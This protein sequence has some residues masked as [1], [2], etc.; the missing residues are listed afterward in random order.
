MKNLLDDFVQRRSLAPSTTAKQLVDGSDYESDSDDD[1]EYDDEDGLRK[2]GKRK[3]IEKP[4]KVNESS[5]ATFVQ[6]SSCQMQVYANAK[7]S[8]KGYDT[9]QFVSSFRKALVPIGNHS[10]I[11]FGSGNSEHVSNDNRQ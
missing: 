11:S 8:N 2:K 7:I 4:K 6:C 10:T 5:F 9:S 1:D 3:R